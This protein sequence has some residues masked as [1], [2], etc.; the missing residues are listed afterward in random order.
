MKKDFK[1]RFR[2]YIR[3]NKGFG[4][5]EIAAALGFIV[6]VGLI[7]TAIKGDLLAG[8][9]GDIWDWISSFIRDNISG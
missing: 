4:I 7:I 3:S 8:W 6:V 1:T 2:A 9:L 5:K